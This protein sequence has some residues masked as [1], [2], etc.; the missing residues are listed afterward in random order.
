[1]EAVFGNQLLGIS[2]W[3]PFGK[4]ARMAGEEEGWVRQVLYAMLD[5]ENK[6]LKSLTVQVK[7]GE[8]HNA[9]LCTNF[10]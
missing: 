3:E 9:L 10:E 1:M 7:T 2:F 8:V 6:Q 5:F 4:I